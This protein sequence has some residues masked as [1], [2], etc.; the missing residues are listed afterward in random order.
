MSY[1]INLGGW[2]SIFAVPSQVVD[3]DLKLASGYQLKVLLYLLR[4]SSE[5]LTKEQIG[6]VLGMHPEDV[7]DCL[8]Y[9]ISK[10]LLVE[11]DDELLPSGNTQNKVPA[12]VSSVPKEEAQAQAAPAETV[13]TEKTQA[14]PKQKPRPMSRPQRPDSFFV[15]QRLTQDSNLVA[16]M[17]EAQIILGKPLS[18]G[19]TATLLMLH[20]TDGL[21]VDVL[22][23][24]MQYCVSAGKGNFRAIERLGIQW[25][26]EGIFT[27]EAAEEKIKQTKERYNAWGIVSSTFGVK[28]VGSPTKKQLEYS[29][30]WVNQWHFTTDMLREAYELCVDSKGEMNLKYIDGILKRWQADNIKCLDDIA[31][32]GAKKSGKKSNQNETQSPSY[33]LSEF[34]DSS[35]FDD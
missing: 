17:D 31:K 2:N 19:D 30:K 33:D 27:L 10:G 23:M 34:E 12:A 8:S 1:N 6:E 22:I 29:E 32:K 18:S 25:A 21:P 9:W 26:S 3:N 5:N 16:L 35:I 14:Q 24:L 11:K 7:A 20:D 28:N 15:A 4:H 13:S